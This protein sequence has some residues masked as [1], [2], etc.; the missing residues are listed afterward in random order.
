M[1]AGQKNMH[2]CMPALSWGVGWELF[3]EALMR[4]RLLTVLAFPGSRRY[5]RKSFASNGLGATSQASDSAN[6]CEIVGKAES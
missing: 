3:G 1:T 4:A 5:V 2:G 6:K